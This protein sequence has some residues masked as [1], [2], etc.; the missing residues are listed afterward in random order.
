MLTLSLPPFWRHEWANC[1]SLV[2]KLER[3]AAEF[4]FPELILNCLV[5]KINF[6]SFESNRVYFSYIF[7]KPGNTRSTQW[8]LETWKLFHAFC[9]K[10]KNSRKLCRGGWYLDHEDAS[11]PANERI[12]NYCGKTARRGLWYRAR[13]FDDENRRQFHENAPRSKFAV[14]ILS[15]AV[16]PKSYRLV[17]KF[18]D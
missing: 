3:C 7:I 9:L 5:R 4:L 8:Q 14:I 13:R 6:C 11:S 10:T 12:W 18:T 16:C 15:N 1:T 17:S 2:A